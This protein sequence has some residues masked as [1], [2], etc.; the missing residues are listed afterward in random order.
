MNAHI[1]IIEDVPEMAELISIY[2]QKSGME[3]EKCESAEIAL[4]CLKKKVPDL[5]VLDL[6][7]PGMS[8]LD[9]LKKFRTEYKKTIPVVIVSARDSDEDIITALG[10]GADEFVTKPFS[11]HVLA[12]RIE[13]NL[14]RQIAT[15]AAAE[16][17]LQFGPYTLYLNS[18]VLKKGIEKIPLSTKE[19]EVLEYL[20]KNAGQSLSPEKIYNGVWKTQYGDITAVA[21]YI[22]RLRKKIETDPANPHFIKTM[23]GMGY[24]FD[25]SNNDENK[26]SI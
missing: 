6:N 24:R 16:E 23:F 21:V 8:G 9:F 20:A 2:L 3:T 17:T 12:A 13:A 11:P 1:L 25:F 18:C 19:Y 26:K 10:Y 7:L 22:Q 14:R 4:E 5:V 15:E